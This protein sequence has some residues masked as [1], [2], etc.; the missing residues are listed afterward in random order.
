MLKSLE[1]QKSFKLNQ[2]FRA[3]PVSF[4]DGPTLRGDARTN[5]ADSLPDAERPWQ[6]RPRAEHGDEVTKDK[7]QRTNL[8][9]WSE[10]PPR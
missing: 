7:G 3:N 4:V 9:P 1:N 6:V 5:D 2:V 10:A 8:R